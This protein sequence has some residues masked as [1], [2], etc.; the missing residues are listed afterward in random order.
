MNI[1]LILIILLIVIM[2]YLFIK[3]N[4]KNE[5]AGNVGFSTEAYSS[6][7]SVLTNQN[8]KLPNI[9]FVKVN[10]EDG[11]FSKNVKANTLNITGNGEF[12]QNLKANC[13]GLCLN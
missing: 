9:S 10:S 3:S 5:H 4:N 12:N 1:K 2:I 11:E 8:V 7:A 13:L 6:F